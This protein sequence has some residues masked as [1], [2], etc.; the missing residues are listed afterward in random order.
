MLD[1]LS[2]Q[3][4]LTAAGE[5]YPQNK[6]AYPHRVQVYP[7][8]VSSEEEAETCGTFNNGITYILM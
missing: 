3:L 1:I 2:H 7:H 8:L 6:R 4:T 5:T